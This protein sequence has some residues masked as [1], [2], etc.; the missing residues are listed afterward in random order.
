V[1]KQCATDG[2]DSW[3][4]DWPY[5][6]EF[7]GTTTCDTVAAGAFNLETFPCSMDMSDSHVNAGSYATY[8]FMGNPTI[9]PTMGPSSQAP[10]KY[11]ICNSGTVVIFITLLALL[12]W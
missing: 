2:I 12:L 7:P 3:K 6:Y 4:Y 1:D 5:Y 9:A 10:S 8:N 11:E